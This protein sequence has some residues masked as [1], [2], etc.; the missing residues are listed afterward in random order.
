MR[1][2]TACAMVK[3]M[4]YVF[5]ATRTKIP[6]HVPTELCPASEIVLDDAVTD[7]DVQFGDGGQNAAEAEDIP[8]ACGTPVVQHVEC[9]YYRT[10]TVTQHS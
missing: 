1:R 5:G 4:W 10:S 2:F 9:Q 6:S 7:P 3:S 8:V